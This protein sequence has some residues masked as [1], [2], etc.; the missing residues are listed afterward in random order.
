MG[1]FKEITKEEAKRRYCNHEE[2]L[3]C[4]K[5]RFYWQMTPSWKYGSYAPIEELFYRSIPTGEGE[6]RFY[7]PLLT[8]EQKDRQRRL[9]AKNGW[10]LT[11]SMKWNLYN[12]HRAARKAG[13]E[14][15][16]AEIEYR[17]TDANFHS[18]SGK[19]CSGDYQAARQEIKESLK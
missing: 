13:D 15:R 7:K 14:V 9:N 2:V 4:N 12:K 5:E 19:L 10:G 16:M 6:N 17:L 18:L 11:Y 1:W 3:I 8:E